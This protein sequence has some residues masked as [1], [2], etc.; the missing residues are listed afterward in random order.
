MEEATPDWKAKEDDA[1]RAIG[2]YF[3]EFSMLVSGMRGYLIQGI[4]DSDP[5]RNK[6]AELA[7]GSQTAQQIADSFFA[8]CRA[9]GDL[10]SAERGIEKCLREQVNAAIRRRNVVAHGDWLVD[11]PMDA[12]DDIA[13][14]VRV[15]AASVKD[16][17]ITERL[18]TLDIDHDRASVWLLDQ[19]ASVFAHACF[20]DVYE[21]ERVR[22]VLEIADGQVIN[23]Q[24]Y[25]RRVARER[26]D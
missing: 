21:S 16:P 25:L 24:A 17:F 18:S 5:Q 15:K 13:W 1:Y 3:A 6:L 26:G 8:V 23:N 7:L 14:L 4:A 12:D 9:V 11:A 22:Q 20:K 10:D 2:H 19:V